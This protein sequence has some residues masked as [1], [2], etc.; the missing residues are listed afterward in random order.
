ME[1]IEHDTRIQQNVYKMGEIL[2][3]RVG[4][5]GLIVT[6]LAVWPICRTFTRVLPPTPVTLF[7]PAAASG[8]KKA[9]KR[10]QFWIRRW[11]HRAES[12]TGI[13]NQSNNNTL[14]RGWTCFCLSSSSQRHLGTKNHL[15]ISNHQDLRGSSG[16]F[17]KICLC[18]SKAWRQKNRAVFCFGQQHSTFKTMKSTNEGQP[19]RAPFGKQVH[20]ASWNWFGRPEALGKPNED[21]SW[22]LRLL[23]KIRRIRVWRCALVLVWLSW[24]C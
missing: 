6:R 17:F 23:G 16:L 5:E 1:Q 13:S 15:K 3:G 21:N 9:D 4:L 7:G 8:G 22:L 18:H 14:H 11:G 19:N 2:H 20:T 24:E 12:S 10:L